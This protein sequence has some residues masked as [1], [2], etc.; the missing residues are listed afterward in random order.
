LARVRPP[1]YA[2]QKNGIMHPHRV[3]LYGRKI[4]EIMPLVERFG[5]ETVEENPQ[6]VVSYGGDGT[7]LAAEQQWP[8]VPKVALRRSDRC[9]TCS[10]HSNETILRHLAEG[11]L[12][13]TDFVKLEAKTEKGNLICLNDIM[14]RNARVNTAARFLVWIYYEVYRKEEIVRGGLV[15]STPFGS[16]AYFRSIAQCTFRIG[17]GLAFNNT[18]EPINN[19]IVGDASLI[20]ILVTRGPAALAADNNPKLLELDRDDEIL[21]RRSEQTAVILAFDKIHYPADQFIY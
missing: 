18:T 10:H 15:V 3:K 20:R 21:I 17:I 13:R 16:T 9:R 11:K 14:L 4:E 1:P 5:L 19:V 2:R 12:R 8:G 7:L 6:V